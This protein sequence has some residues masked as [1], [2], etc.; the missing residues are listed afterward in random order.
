[1]LEVSDLGGLVDRCGGLGEEEVT[2]CHSQLSP[3]EHQRV[4]WARL[5]YH[6]P[7]LASCDEANITVPEG[8]S[9]VHLIH[10]LLLRGCPVLVT[11]GPNGEH[12]LVY[13]ERT[14]LLGLD[15]IRNNLV[16]QDQFGLE[17]PFVFAS[18]MRIKLKF[19]F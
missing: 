16:F 15:S 3:G 17:H 5:L 14:V 13:V 9:H 6:N 12:H 19:S 10:N 4:A 8:L 11:V 2:N 18:L 1:M 7:M